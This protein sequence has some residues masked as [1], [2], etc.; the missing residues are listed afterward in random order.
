MD[1]ILQQ[2]RLQNQFQVGVNISSTNQ[3]S[4]LPAP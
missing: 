4:N 3:Q 1:I 2:A